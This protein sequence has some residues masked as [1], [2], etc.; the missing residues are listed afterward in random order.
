MPSP[1]T[2]ETLTAVQRAQRL[3][4]KPPHD[5]VNGLIGNAN[6]NESMIAT[7]PNKQEQR[8][9][10]QARKS[11]PP[12]SGPRTSATADIDPMRD[13]DDSFSILPITEIEPYRFNPRQSQNPRYNE[14]KASIKAGGITNPITVTRRSLQDR[15]TPYGGGNTRLQVAKELFAEGDRRFAQLKVIVKDWPGDAQVITAHLAENELR[16]DITFWEKARGVQQFRIELE[17][18]QGRSLSA[19]EL[20]RE[21][22]SSGLNFGVRTIQNFLFAMEEL[23]P[24]GPW[25]K[26]REVNE[27]VRPTV[28]TILDLGARLGSESTLRSR[29]QQVMQTYGSELAERTKENEDLEEAERQIIELDTPALLDDLRQASAEQFS[30]SPIALEAMLE[31]L[32][33]DPKASPEALRSAG[34][35]QPAAHAE[36]RAP[37]QVM[38]S[39]PPEP[40]SAPI[41]PTAA[42]Q[43]PLPGMLAGVTPAHGPSNQPRVSAPKSPTSQPPTGSISEALA[44]VRNILGEINDVVPLHDVLCA[45]SSMPFGFMVDLPRESVAQASGVPIDPAKV[46]LRAALIKLLAALTYQ[47]D[48]R[49]M[50]AIPAVH[51][52][53]TVWTSSWV[54]G[55]HVFESACAAKAGLPVIGNQFQIGVDELNLVLAAPDVGYSFVRLL[56]A[57]EQMRLQFPERMPE[58]HEPLF[59]A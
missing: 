5:Q 1:R 31:R 54:A 35:S 22:R 38:G 3:N 55:R 14:L 58:G 56:S 9:M 44:G 43:T 41:V 30:V 37:E 51:V 53:E 16:A 34:Q 2:P 46:A 57:L 45:L 39:D 52:E 49:C 13:A 18:E 24:V 40:T 7:K 42:Q 15:Y 32:S 11:L 25:L 20:N 12:I 29:L 19:G 28:A 23:A 36:A 21:L 4:I 27:S 8:I 6:R 26:A 50:T 48:R 33:A 59:G 17:R 47:Y 10:E